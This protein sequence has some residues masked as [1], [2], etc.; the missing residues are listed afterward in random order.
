ML[1]KWTVAAMLIQ[2][3]AGAAV[4]IKC[5]RLSFGGNEQACSVAIF[6]D[7]PR[8]SAPLHPRG[9][10]FAFHLYEQSLN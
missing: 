5:P 4:K 9:P 3:G 6:A 7:T 8:Q 1:S 2:S 10:F